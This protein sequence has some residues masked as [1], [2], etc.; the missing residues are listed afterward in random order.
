MTISVESG[1]QPSEVKG[2]LIAE[3]LLAKDPK[4]RSHTDTLPS[5]FLPQSVGL[6]ASFPL[7]LIPALTSWLAAALGF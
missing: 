2:E 4:T 6:S 7:S 1:R 3:R 5:F